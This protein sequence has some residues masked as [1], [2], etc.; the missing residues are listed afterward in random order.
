[1]PSQGLVKGVG[2]EIEGRKEERRESRRSREETGEDENRKA[3]EGAEDVSGRSQ[4]E[5]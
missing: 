1:M 2:I 4:Q 5:E 3:K